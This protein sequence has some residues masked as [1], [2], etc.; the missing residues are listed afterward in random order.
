[1]KEEELVGRLEC[2][3]DG[4]K[5]VLVDMNGKPVRINDWLLSGAMS[6]YMGV[7]VKLTIRLDVEGGKY[8]A[9]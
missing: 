1:M 7:R 4:E 3:A 2:S 6:D 5:A 8:N 9:E